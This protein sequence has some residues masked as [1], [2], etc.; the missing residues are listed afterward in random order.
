MEL[1]GLSQ[2]MRSGT[3][4]SSDERELENLREEAK[5]LTQK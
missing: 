3:F 1:N 5:L 2:L 4:G